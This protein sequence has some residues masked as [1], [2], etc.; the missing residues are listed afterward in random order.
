[1]GAYFGVKT[2]LGRLEF[3]TNDE[4]DI[5]ADKLSLALGRIAYTWYL[6]N[7]FL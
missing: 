3:E 4:V 2:E 6:F 7:Y 1:M 5:F